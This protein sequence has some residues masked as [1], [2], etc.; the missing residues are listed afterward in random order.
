MRKHPNVPGWTSNTHT[1]S[2]LCNSFSLLLVSVT[3]TL[4]HPS[5]LLPR[6]PQS[7]QPW[8]LLLNSATVTNIEALFWEGGPCAP[9][10]LHVQQAGNTGHRELVLPHGA[11]RGITQRAAAHPHSHSVPC[12]VQV[13]GW[14]HTCIRLPDFFNMNASSLLEHGARKARLN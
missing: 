13:P 2:I 5:V 7:H 4:L 1:V 12:N 3:V 10:P 9:A 6:T 8:D 14:L 11:I